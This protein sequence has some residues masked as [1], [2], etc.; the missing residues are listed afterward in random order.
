MYCTTTWEGVRTRVLDYV[1]TVPKLYRY[2]IVYFVLPYLR[3]VCMFSPGVQILIYGVPP[4][5]SVLRTLTG[6][7]QD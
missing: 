7:V 3:T 2:C 6:N 4:H 1:L 5:T